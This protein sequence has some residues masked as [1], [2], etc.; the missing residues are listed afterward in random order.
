MLTSRERLIQRGV[1]R[2]HELVAAGLLLISPLGWAQ[3][4][5]AGPAQGSQLRARLNLSQTVTD[6]LELSSGNK[7]AALITVVSPGVTW[8]SR[9]GSLRGSVD[10]SLDGIAYTKTER[11]S[12]LQNALN[13]NLSAE[14][15]DRRLFVDVRATVGQQSQSAFGPQTTTPEL[16]AVNSREVGTLS[17]S[18]YLVGQLGGWASYELRGNFSRTETRGS[19]LGDNRSAGGSARLSSAGA[20]PLSA[21]LLLSTQRSASP[22]ARST[23][24]DS[25]S[26]GLGYRPDTDVQLGVN[27]GRE[28]ND[29]LTGAQAANGVTVGVS[30]NWTPSP[31]TS[32]NGSWQRHDYGNSHSLGF[33]HRMARSVW[34]YS[35]S[36]SLNLGNVG[37]NGGVRTNYDQYYLLFASLEP[38]PVKRDALV[39]A[40]LQQLGISPDA[41]IA[42]GFLSAGPTRLT[43]QQLAV[44]LQEQRGSLTALVGRTVTDRVGDNAGVGDLASSAQIEQR[45]YSLTAAYQLTPLTSLSLSAARQETDGDGA[46]QSTQL[47]SYS[48]NLSTRFGQRLS[49]QLG[50][51]RSRSTGL[52]AYTENAVFANLTQQF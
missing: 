52:Q 18:P 47:T 25:L 42:N 8:S 30:A 37:T 51:R 27:L 49:G 11:G 2:G 14:L 12:R 46:A 39:R 10:Y 4:A 35:D 31:R 36:R 43:S 48:L 3:E 44:T 45:S 23:Q 15:I 33:E 32:L 20:G 5:P 6:N 40:Y 24:N 34:R 7:D 21:W 41:P 19:S 1:G 9:S 28:R 13:A 38:D 50:G 26:V 16:N 29:Y 22:E 17:T